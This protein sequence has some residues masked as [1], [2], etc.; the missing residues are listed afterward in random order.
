M[1]IRLDYTA[2]GQNDGLFNIALKNLLL[3]HERYPHALLY[4]GAN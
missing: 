2:C 3:M 4:M 1:P